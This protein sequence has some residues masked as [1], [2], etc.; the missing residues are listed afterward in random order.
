MTDEKA[1]HLEIGEGGGE[2]GGA[3]AQVADELILGQGG[4][5]EP[6]EDAGAEVGGGVFFGGGMA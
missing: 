5:A 6:L 3:L 4:G 2:G 1:V